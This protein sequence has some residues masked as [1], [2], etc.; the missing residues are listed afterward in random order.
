MALPVRDFLAEEHRRQSLD[1][2]EVTGSDHQ[3]R[4]AH[5]HWY[6]HN[7]QSGDINE[8]VCGTLRSCMQSV[9]VKEAAVS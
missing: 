7:V 9:H 5:W 4:R 2:R 3:V 1:V 6:F 8:G